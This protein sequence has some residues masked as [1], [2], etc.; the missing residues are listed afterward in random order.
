MKTDVKKACK[1][2]GLNC[3][4]AKDLYT[5][6]K[7]PQSAFKKAMR[8]ELMKDGKNLIIPDTATGL[9]NTVKDLMNELQTAGYSVVV[10]MI[11]SP[12]AQCF[13]NGAGLE[14]KESTGHAGQYKLSGTD[15]ARDIGE[16]KKYSP[17]AWGWSISRALDV[18]NHCKNKN[19][20]L[21]NSFLVIDNTDVRA[22]TTDKIAKG[23]LWRVDKQ[24]PK[25]VCSKPGKSDASCKS[26]TAA[27]F[28]V[29]DRNVKPVSNPS[30]N[31]GD[32][33]VINEA[34]AVSLLAQCS[35]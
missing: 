21:G 6:M 25:F 7:P 4:G 14:Y 28:E 15:A 18:F 26:S 22:T 13:R 12:V 33:K 1:L 19:I 3:V 10:T 29:E 20:G 35:H 2:G 16:G 27:T 17:K 32:Q 9:T 11:Y 24:K 5:E 30:K 23:I 31:T 34:F 8:K